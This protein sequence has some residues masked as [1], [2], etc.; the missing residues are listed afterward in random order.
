MKT[1]RVCKEQK[2]IEA[3]AIDRRRQDGRSSR[4]RGCRRG[5]YLAEKPQ[6]Q[7]RSAA[8]HL[9]NRERSN[10]RNLAYYRDHKAARS[11]KMASWYETNK[12]RVADNVRAFRAANPGFDARK[13]A[14]RR[15][16][17]KRAVP[18]WANPTKMAEIY[19]TAAWLTEQSGEPWHV[20]HIVPIQS[21]L[22]CGLHCEANLTLLPASENI[23]KSNRWW[24]DMFDRPESAA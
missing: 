11:C 9:R 7:R 21:K 24:P 15:A 14:Q 6:A 12:Q 17:L 16:T 13:R 2:T 4:C 5:V 1:C 8:Y 20:D 18:A 10:A 22:V 3:F 23:S 19:E